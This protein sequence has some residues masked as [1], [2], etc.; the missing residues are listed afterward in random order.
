MKKSAWNI[1]LNGSWRAHCFQT[2][3][4]TS[5]GTEPFQKMSKRSSERAILRNRLVRSVP[6]YRICLPHSDVINRYLYV[7]QNYYLPDDILYKCDRMS[8]AHSIEVRP[9]FLDHRI[10]EFAAR[11]PA[12]LKI[13][14]R[15]TKHVL[16]K[17]V[18]TK[19]PSEILRRGKE[20]LDIPA[21]EWLRGPLRPLV[22]EALAQSLSNE[23]V[24][25]PRKRLRQLSSDT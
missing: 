2:M 3:R 23:P 8:M 19:L 22:M 14:G 17:L 13:N 25:S 10:V 16:R 18:S 4:P 12:R 5:I 9:P 24:S 20:G 21:H 7:D 15:S 11:L 6:R 1:N